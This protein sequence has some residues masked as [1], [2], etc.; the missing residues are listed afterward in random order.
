[1][2]RRAKVPDAAAGVDADLGFSAGLRSGSAAPGSLEL[3]AHDAGPAD[4]ARGDAVEPLATRRMVTVLRRRSDALSME[5]AA[6][7]RAVR[8]RGRNRSYGRPRCCRLQPAVTPGSSGE[9]PCRVSCHRRSAPSRHGCGK[10][11]PPCVPPASPPYPARRPTPVIHTRGAFP[12]QVFPLDGSGVA[13]QPPRRHNRTKRKDTPSWRCPIILCASSW[14]P[15][16]ISATTPAGGT[17]DGAVLYRRAQPGAH[18][19]S[20][21]DRPVCSTEHC[22]Q[23][24]T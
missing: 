4:V 20:A 22:A 1:M 16:C 8:V 15:A 10:L 13:R 11:P 7:R 23:S 17:R 3:R 12:G 2:L 21:T 19:R 6:W 14:K 9:R 24:V 18:H 5:V